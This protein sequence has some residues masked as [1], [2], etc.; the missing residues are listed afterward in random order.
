[1]DYVFGFCGGNVTPFEGQKVRFLCF[2]V[3]A[4]KEIPLKRALQLGFVEHF[5]GVPSWG[6]PGGFYYSTKVR[7]LKLDFEERDGLQTFAFP[8]V[9]ELGGHSLI[10]IRSELVPRFFFRGLG[11]FLGRGEAAS[12]LSGSIVSANRVLS[13]RPPSKEQL[14]RYVSLTPF[15]P[16]AGV[17]RKIRLKGGMEA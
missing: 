17:V 14:R 8:F 4:G 3:H 5:S 10:D 7:T 2:L 6:T 1:M 15:R 12:R 11:R 16:E 13:A 9:I